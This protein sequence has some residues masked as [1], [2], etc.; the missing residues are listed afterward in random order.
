MA[1]MCPLLMERPPTER[2]ALTDDA[3]GAR[4]M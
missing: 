1:C 4:R 2:D 3:E